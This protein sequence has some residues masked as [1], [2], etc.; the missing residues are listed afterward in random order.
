[1]GRKSKGAEI[2]RLLQKIRSFIPE[3]SLRSSFIVGF[4]GEKETQFKALLDFVEEIQF[5]HLGA[6][7]YSSE[8]GT[9]ASRLPHPIPETLKEERLK[10][11]METQGKISLKKYQ[12]L[13][14]QR[15]LVLVEGTQ[16]ERGLLRGRLQI[17]AP[18]IDGSVLL[19]GKARPGDWVEARMIQ[20]LPYD[21]IARIE[22]VLP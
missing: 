13:V 2:R 18:E 22:R 15:K 3:V 19:K 9:P 21:L 6:F 17:Q 14:G 10:I 16:R 1:M 11:L 20:T 4:P 7:K 12:A 8:E 5:D